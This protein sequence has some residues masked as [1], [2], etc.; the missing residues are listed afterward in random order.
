MLVGVHLGT[1]GVQSTIGTAVPNSEHA[2]DYCVFD[3]NVVIFFFHIYCLIPELS[4]N[5]LACALGSEYRT[6]GKLDKGSIFC[7]QLLKNMAWRLS[8]LN[9]FLGIYI[10]YTG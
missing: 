5:L 3:T 1:D 9:P 6:I 8:L 7:A 2:D 10:K 4:S